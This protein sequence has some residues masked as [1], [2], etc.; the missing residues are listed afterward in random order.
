MGKQSAL[1]N[2]AAERVVLSGICQYG[3]DAWL[4]AE[5]FLEEATF[6]VDINK[7]LYSCIK[8]ALSN[9]SKIDLSTILS[10]AQTLSLNEIV[11]IPENLRH[12]NGM[13]SSKFYYDPPS[14]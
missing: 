5:S 8:H 14:V 12:L 3:E 4:D 7:V 6:T 10:S 13:F 11:N 2:P 9:K 1:A